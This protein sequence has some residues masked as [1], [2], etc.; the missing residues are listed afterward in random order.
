[1]ENYKVSVKLY[2]YFIFD[3]CPWLVGFSLPPRASTLPLPY[4]NTPVRER[5]S[6]PQAKG[7]RG[8]G[9][10]RTM[11]SSHLFFSFLFYN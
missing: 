8:G 5:E 2:F 11:E 3:P 6:D 4:A 1:M 10:N 7:G 9:G